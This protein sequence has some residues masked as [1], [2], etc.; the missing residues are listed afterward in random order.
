MRPTY[1]TSF[2]LAGLPVATSILTL[3]QREKAWAIHK[4]P[5]IGSYRFLDLAIGDHSKYPEILSRLKT[6]EQIY[7][8]LG[9]AFAQ[10]LRKLVSDGVD[11]SKTFGADLRLDFMDLGYELFNDKDT[12]KT[13][14]IEADI[15]EQESALKEL[16][17]K[18]DIIGASSFFHLFGW[19]DQKRVAHRV[20]KLMKPQS[21]SMV[22]GRQAGQATP[23]E[24]TRPGGNHSR[25]RHNLESWKNMWKEIGDETG[26]EFDVSGREK[27]LTG[28]LAKFREIGDLF[29]EFTVRRV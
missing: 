10:D 26:V 4:Y 9:C 24:K 29:F 8:D 13:K 1:Q 19:E 17:G 6:G 2:V 28:E 22:V 14:F 15:F 20:V 16:D 21:G 12:L 18:V 27:Y 25:Y 11:S 3:C 23:G 5:C 7:L